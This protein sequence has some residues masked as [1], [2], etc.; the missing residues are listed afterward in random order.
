VQG[1]AIVVSLL[2]LLHQM[3]G[4]KKEMKAIMFLC[5]EVPGVQVRGTKTMDS[6]NNTLHAKIHELKAVHPK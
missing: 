2:F 1:I 4:E 6:R 3:K 5:T